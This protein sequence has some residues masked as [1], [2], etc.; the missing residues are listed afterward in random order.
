M[1]FPVI[2]INFKVYEKAIGNNA[3]KLAKI[4]ETISKKFKINIIISPQCTDLYI[5]KKLKIP[6]FSQHF[7]PIEQ[8]AYTGSL[9]IKAVKSAGV[10]G[11]FINHSEKKLEIEKIKKCIQLAKKYNILSLC[12]VGNLNEAKKVLKFKPD[13]IAYEPPELIGTGV[14]VSKSKPEILKKFSKLVGKKSVPLAGAGISNKEDV[15]KALEWVK[16]VLIASA[17]V[18]SNNPKRFLENIVKEIKC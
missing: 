14:S 7:D 3:L 12:C 2:I 15:I 9:S 10:K 5:G 1:K 4:C 17:F 18:K 8:G 6:V 16:G 13:L 11:S